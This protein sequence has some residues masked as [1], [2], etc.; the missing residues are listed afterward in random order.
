MLQCFLTRAAAAVS[1]LRET[2]VIG[3]LTQPQL[4]FEVQLLSFTSYNKS[5]SAWG[6]GK[7]ERVIYPGRGCNHDT[8]GQQFWPLFCETQ[9][10]IEQDELNSDGEKS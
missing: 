7:R 1:V 3:E 10:E 2:T 4:N 9:T 8:N 6:K 5:C